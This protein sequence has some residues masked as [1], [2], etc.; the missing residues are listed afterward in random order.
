MIRDFALRSRRRD[1][2]NSS[3]LAISFAILAVKELLGEI[4]NKW[5][6]IC[7]WILSFFFWDIRGMYF[8]GG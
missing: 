3:S 1:F 4:V 7:S 6:R 2:V 5:W 8:V